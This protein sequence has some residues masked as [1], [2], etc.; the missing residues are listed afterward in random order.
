MNIKI[1]R[2]RCND[3]FDRTLKEINRRNKIFEKRSKKW[4][5]SDN[6]LSYLADIQSLRAFNHRIYCAIQNL[7]E[8]TDYND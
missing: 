4:Q 5:D 1:E 2:A 6:G 3:I 8:M 7:N